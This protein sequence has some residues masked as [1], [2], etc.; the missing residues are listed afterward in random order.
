M[1]LVGCFSDCAPLQTLTLPFPDLENI[2]SVVMDPELGSSVARQLSAI[3]LY[4]S[5]MKSDTSFT[6]AVNW[7]TSNAIAFATKPVVAQSSAKAV[8]SIILESSRED[9]AGDFMLAVQME[10]YQIIESLL[11]TVW[12]GEWAGDATWLIDCVEALSVLCDHPIFSPVLMAQSSNPYLQTTILDACVYLLSIAHSSAGWEDNRTLSRLRPALRR[13]GAFVTEIM[14]DVMLTLTSNATPML[15]ENAEK[16]N[17]IYDMFTSDPRLFEILVHI[18]DEH[19]I[20]KRSCEIIS[21][22]DLA[23]DQSRQHANVYRILLELHRVVAQDAAGAGRLSTAEAI[24]TYSA[25]SLTELA[26]SQRAG[27]TEAP[28]LND[29][30]ANML[31]NIALVLRKLPYITTIVSEEVLPF[32]NRVNSRVRAATEWEL[33]GESSLGGLR[34]VIAML[35]ILRHIVAVVADDVE[36]KMSLLHDHSTPLLRLLRSITNAINKPNLIQTYLEQSIDSDKRLPAATLG[37]IVDNE[38]ASIMHSLILAADSIVIILRD[39][40]YAMQV[41]RRS[42]DANLLAPSCVLS[43]VSRHTKLFIQRLGAHAKNPVSCLS[44]FRPSKF[45]L[46]W[47][48]RSKTSSFPHRNPRHLAEANLCG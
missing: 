34:E 42:P 41:I 7:Y 39:L 23:G 36:M 28:D 14:S 8:Q 22:L 29:L 30:W 38:A 43:S 33:H 2:T 11:Q 35:E 45:C 18:L 26:S 27:P 13:I 17:A 19:G 16:I 40:T 44:T 15:L 37:S 10:R 12:R 24:P 6:A 4:W 46:T 9:R 1:A 21:Q 3:N 25:S 48:R 32:I 47:T 20:I 5:E 31:S